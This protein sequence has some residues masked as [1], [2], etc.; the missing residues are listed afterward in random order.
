MTKRNWCLTKGGNAVT[1]W[2]VA[3]AG[4]LIG[5]SIGNLIIPPIIAAIADVPS[6][7]DLPSRWGLIQIVLVGV[8]AVSLAAVGYKLSSR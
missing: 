3:I 8:F 2:I 1:K 5:M 4:I 6:V 7:E